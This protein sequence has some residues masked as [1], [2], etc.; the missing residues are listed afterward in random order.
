MENPLLKIGFNK[1][2]GVFIFQKDEDFIIRVVELHKKGDEVKLGDSY[3][4]LIEE[5]FQFND[6]IKSKEPS[7]LF[8]H[9]HSMLHKLSDAT[10]ESTF[11]N[12]NKEE[13]YIDSQ[14]LASG[15]YH[16]IIRK[17]DLKSLLTQFGIEEEQLLGIVLNPAV[18]GEQL[19]YFEVAPNTLLNCNPYLLKVNAGQLDDIQLINNSNQETDTYINFGDERI[20]LK[21][22]LPL[23]AALEYFIGNIDS[24]LDKG[25]AFESSFLVWASRKIEKIGVK[26]VLPIMLAI[27]LIITLLYTN[28]YQTNQKLS[29][30]MSIYIA[31]FKNMINS[32]RMQMQR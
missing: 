8:L 32:K 6:F 24:K 10:L 27:A 15:N 21:Y 22:L 30:E 1:V 23:S 26:Y 5:D 14:Q 4:K 29:A 3:E 12:L 18:V 9:A 11:P 13:F 2:N 28:T 20:G 31:Y 19:S 25:I 17:S 7:I 16:T